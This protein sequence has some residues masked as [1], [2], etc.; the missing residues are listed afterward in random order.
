MQ[1][2]RAD[3]D[4]LGRKEGGV[5]IKEEQLKFERNVGRR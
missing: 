4:G 1:M 2:T 5:K 3:M